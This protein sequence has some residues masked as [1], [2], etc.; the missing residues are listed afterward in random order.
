[1]TFF[2]DNPPKSMDFAYEVAKWYTVEDE[3]DEENDRFIEREDDDDTSP[4]I[5][6]LTDEKYRRLEEMYL[7]SQEIPLPKWA[8]ISPVK[9]GKYIGRFLPRE[10]AR[11]MF[12]GQYTGCCQHPENAAYGAAFDAVLSPKA[13]GF[14][15][16]DASK[17]YTFSL[18]F[19]KT[20]MEMFVLI[21]L[22]LDLETFSI[23]NKEKQ[24]LHK[25]FDK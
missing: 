10:D 21:H 3:D 25:L 1:M 2:G 14:V 13:C 7:L 5:E 4:D 15:I 17:K 9:V 19:G 22:K 24:W 12:L 8:Q 18:M 20:E 16:E 23:A 11:T 6:E